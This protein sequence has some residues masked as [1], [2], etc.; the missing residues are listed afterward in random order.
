MRRASLRDVFLSVLAFLFPI[1]NAHGTPYTPALNSLLYVPGITTD[2]DG[3]SPLCS[4]G[5][6]ELTSIIFVDEVIT[7]FAPVSYTHLRAHET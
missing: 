3:I 5:L 4:I 1:I 6:L 7:T 2:L